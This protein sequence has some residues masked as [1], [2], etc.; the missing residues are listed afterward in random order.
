M[1]SIDQHIGILVLLLHDTSKKFPVCQNLWVMLWGDE[2]VHMILNKILQVV[3][4]ESIFQ[5]MYMMHKESQSWTLN[6][7]ILA[8]DS[9]PL[10]T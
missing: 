5:W 2:I 9:T 6:V 7:D 10:P 4:G 8:K 1:S 3:S